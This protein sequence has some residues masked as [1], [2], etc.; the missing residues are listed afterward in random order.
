M[1]Y[2]IFLFILGACVGSFLNVCIYR[3]PKN[4]SIVNPPS[5]CPKCNKLIAWY[6]NIPFISYIILGA[7][8]RHCKTRITFR[9]FLV[10]LLTAIVFAALYGQFGLTAKCFIM[11]ILSGAMIVSTFIDFEY[12][13]IP[14]EITLGG[15]AVGLILSVVFPGIHGQNNFIFGGLYSI[16]GILAGGMSIYLMGA[17]G[18]MIFRKE[19]MGGGDVKYMSMIGAFLGWK[20]V[21]L[22]FFL[23]PFFGSIVGI[24]A[25]L[26]YKQDIIPY[27][28]YLSIAAF[29]STIWGERILDY[30]FF[31]IY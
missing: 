8:C 31:R 27:G 18:Q 30:F 25:K 10:E 24:I 22:T 17:A 21:L 19:A 23:A 16:F 3:L 13:I 4:E 20:M 15:A 12:Q 29:V 6:D 2:Y 26:K 5:H 9:Y 1:I 28:P 11:L 7:K 14:D